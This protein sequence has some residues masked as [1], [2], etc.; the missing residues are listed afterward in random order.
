MRTTDLTRL[1]VLMLVVATA[2]GCRSNAVN[3]GAFAGTRHTRYEI[4][5]NNVG[6]LSEWLAQRIAVEESNSARSATNTLEVWA[7]LRNRIQGSYQITA[8]T[9][10]YGP[11]RRPL[12]TTGW[13]T[14]HLQ[15]LGVATYTTSSLNDN[16]LYY[17]IELREG[18]L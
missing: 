3:E 5:M 8:R 6:V 15:P 13:T 12:E 16:A 17:Y 9:H 4:Q 14:I 2:G 11:D 7:Q 1:A 10:F 18:G